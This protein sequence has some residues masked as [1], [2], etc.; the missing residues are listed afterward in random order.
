MLAAA[1]LPAYTSGN[2]IELAEMKVSESPLRL[3]LKPE[4]IAPLM[5]GSAKSPDF[6]VMSQ[7]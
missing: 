3:I 6:A 5:L 2:D 7:T 4:A 1:M